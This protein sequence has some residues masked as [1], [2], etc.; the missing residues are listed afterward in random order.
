MRKSLDQ[1]VVDTVEIRKR[2]VAFRVRFRALFKF[3]GLHHQVFD[4]K[5]CL[6]YDVVIV[7]F[8][9]FAVDLIDNLRKSFNLIFVQIKVVR[10]R[11]FYDRIGRNFGCFM[12]FAFLLNKIVRFN[13]ARQIESAARLRNIYER[14]EISQKQILFMQFHVLE[15]RYLYQKLVETDKM[16]HDRHYLDLFHQ[17]VFFQFL[18][19]ALQIETQLIF[20]L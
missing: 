11:Q 8:A 10:R 9:R 6:D 7:G 19:G 13:L 2:K 3:F 12:F 14:H 18:L 1:R 4:L 15:T 16:P 20:V 17:F 5:H